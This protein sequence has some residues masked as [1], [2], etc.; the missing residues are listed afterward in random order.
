M[1]LLETK[2]KLQ[3][4]TK[5]PSRFF[6]SKVVNIFLHFL[7]FIWN[8]SFSS[9][10]STVVTPGNLLSVPG[11]LSVCLFSLYFFSHCIPFLSVFLFFLYYFSL[12]IHLLYVST[13]INLPP[14][15]SPFYVSFICLLFIVAIISCLNSFHF[16]VQF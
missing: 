6:S 9:F 4:A 1:N 14:F 15:T 3:M 13:F 10:I 7:F 2:T 11:F 12:C 8:F 5:R 16:P